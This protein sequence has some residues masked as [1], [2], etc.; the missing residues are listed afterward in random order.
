[1][2]GVALPEKSH[3]SRSR[4]IQK[5]QKQFRARGRSCL[6]TKPS[7][8]LRAVMSMARARSKFSH[9]ANIWQ[10]VFCRMNAQ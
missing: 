8:E 3:S 2:R 6:R 5:K 1:V 7:W 4:L 9:I 10:A